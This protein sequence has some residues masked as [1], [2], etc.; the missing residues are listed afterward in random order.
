MYIISMHKFPCPLSNTSPFTQ[1]QL[2]QLRALVSQAV[3]QGQPVPDQPELS[4]NDLLT[5][6][7]LKPL[8]NNP[9]ILE[10]V[11]PH[12]PPDLPVDAPQSEETLRRI[13]ESPQFRASVR[14][15][16]QAL[17]TGLL[18]GF[19]RGLGLPEE[20]GLGVGPFLTAII[21]QAKEKVGDER[22]AMETD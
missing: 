15:L 11:F 9:A 12:L 17:S 6:A 18:A 13:V 3:P 1:E 14:S 8:F 19:V 2:D 16:D 20:A 21:E 22:D 10:A 5:A 7:N 4:L